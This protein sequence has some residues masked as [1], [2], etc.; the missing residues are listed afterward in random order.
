LDY[1][2]IWTVAAMSVL[3]SIAFYQTVVITERRLLD[4]LGMATP[5]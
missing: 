2:M 1:G 5:E 3:V 4:R